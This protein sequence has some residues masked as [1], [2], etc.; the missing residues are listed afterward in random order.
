MRFNTLK[1]KAIGIKSGQK[2]E[3]HG[4]SVAFDFTDAYTDSSAC[5]VVTMDA[6]GE[7]LVMQHV[8]GT[9]SYFAAPDDRLVRAQLRQ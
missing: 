5:R 8:D 6:N 7:H 3:Q 9:R 4:W 1:P 2:D